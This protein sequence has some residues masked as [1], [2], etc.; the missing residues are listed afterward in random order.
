MFIL[1]VAAFATGCGDSSSSNSNLKQNKKQTQSEDLVE[2]ELIELDSEELLISEREEHK[3]RMD[4]KGFTFTCINNC[5][6]GSASE[7]N[8][9][10][11]RIRTP[12]NISNSKS[13]SLIVVEFSFIDDCCK[14]FTGD[15]ELTENEI[16]LTYK[17]ISWVVCDC[18]C[19]YQYRFEIK[20]E[21]HIANAIT[22][23]GKA[24]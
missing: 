16:V 18:Y 9:L 10:K 8:V 23:N 7:E 4:K 17:N 14:E 20:H 19:E 22:L 2:E 24:I 3:I 6:K 11:E 1:I 13:D 15:I 21:T 5:G 12:F